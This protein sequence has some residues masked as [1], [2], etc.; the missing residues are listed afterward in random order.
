MPSPGPV[1]RGKDPSVTVGIPRA[2]WLTNGSTKSLRCSRILKLGIAAARWR[3]A[4]VDTG[5]P[6][7]CGA[8]RTSYDSAHAAC[9]RVSVIPLIIER[10]GWLVSGARQLETS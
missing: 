7:L 8:T 2:A 9:F 1:G 4:A 10:Y 5:P 6:T 3:A